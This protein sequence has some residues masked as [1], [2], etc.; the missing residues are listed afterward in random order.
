MDKMWK[1]WMVRRGMIRTYPCTS[2]C[3]GS[4]IAPLQRRRPS[5]TRYE[6]CMVRKISLPRPT[7]EREMSLKEIRYTQKQGYTAFRRPLLISEN[8]GLATGPETTPRF[9]SFSPIQQEL[10]GRSIR[11]RQEFDQR[12]ERVLTRFTRLCAGLVT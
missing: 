2:S 11:D 3:L 10:E 8:A 6:K 9:P 1:N 12:S 7:Q 5:R 4:D